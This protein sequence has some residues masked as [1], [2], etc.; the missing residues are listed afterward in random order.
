MRVVFVSDY[1]R[2]PENVVG[3][4]EAVVRRLATSMAARADLDVHVVAC[5]RA[6]TTARTEEHEGVTVHRLPGARRLGNVTLGWAERRATRAALR[7]LAPDVVH[8]HVLGPPTL[9]AA[10]AGFPCVATAHGIQNAY[11]RVLAGG[12]VNRVR[13][14]AF[15]RME[16]LSLASVRHLIVISPYVAEF[17]GERLRGVRVYPIENPVEERF[18]GIREPGDPRRILFSGRIVPLKDP[19]TLLAAAAMLGEHGADFTLR[20]A[21]PPDDPAYLDGLRARVGEMGLADRVEFLGSLAPEALAAEMAAAALVVLPSRQETAP[22]AVMEAMAAGRAVV[23]TDVGGTRHLVR[24][25]VTGRLVPP[26]NADR[27]ASA[28]AAFLRDPEGTRRAGEEGRLQATERFR[29]TAVVD[30]T[31]AVYRGLAAPNGRG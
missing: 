13:A 12:A 5:D 4:V 27:L 19:E 16:R 15:T 24:D 29:V 26:R 20:L 23:A 30:K 8:A 21:G 31:L 17:F 18:F 22:L 7:R 3:G 14:W 28:L 2:S 25:G 11:G 6:V 1:P 9:G 10:A